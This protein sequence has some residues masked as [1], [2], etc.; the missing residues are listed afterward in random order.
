MSLPGAAPEGQ[1]DCG[2]GFPGAGL[3]AGLACA[4]L[5]WAS[6]AAVAL[7]TAAVAVL[8]AGVPGGSISTNTS[9]GRI[10]P[11]SVR[12]RSSIASVP[13][14]RLCTSA[15]MAALRAR[16][17]SLAACCWATCFCMSHTLRQPPLPSQSGYWINAVSTNSSR[18]NKRILVP[19]AHTSCSRPPKGD[20]VAR[21]GAARR[22]ARV[23][24]LAN[25]RSPK[26]DNVARLGAAPLVG[27]GSTSAPL[28]QVV[29]SLDTRV[30]SHLGQLLDRK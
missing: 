21:L 20:N 19:P 27:S 10:M 25:A 14:C 23:R 26:G 17:L 15:S 16:M 5:V 12:A 11:S 1:R 29:E 7:A 24:P 4:A 2:L 18:N 13:F 22:L 30:G 6:C 8:G 3:A 28:A 9:P